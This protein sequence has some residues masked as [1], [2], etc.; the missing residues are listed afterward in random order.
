MWRDSPP[1]PPL[2]QSCFGPFWVV[3]GRGHLPLALAWRAHWYVILVI[4]SGPGGSGKFRFIFAL[5]GWGAFK[6]LGDWPLRLE[7]S[8]RSYKF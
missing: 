4:G 1:V 5:C 7:A 6:K 3:L 2:E 8:N